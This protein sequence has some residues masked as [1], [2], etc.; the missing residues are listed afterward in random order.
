M[1]AL[2]RGYRRAKQR[3]VHALAV[4][5]VPVVPEYH[6]FHVIRVSG[7]RLSLSARG[8][9]GVSLESFPLLVHPLQLDA[10]V[11]TWQDVVRKGRKHVSKEL[12]RA[13]PRLVHKV[14]QKTV[15]SALSA[16][17]RVGARGIASAAVLA[18]AA[19]KPPKYGAAAGGL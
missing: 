18:T 12:F 3:R 2:R 9:W 4:A 8:F 16:A 7:L 17:A 6:Y 1:Q 13:A 11:L 14:V 15:T 5:D 19:M 10:K